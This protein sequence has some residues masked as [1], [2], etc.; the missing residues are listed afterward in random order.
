MKIFMKLTN[1]VI[2]SLTV[3]LTLSAGIW[4][5]QARAGRGVMPAGDTSAWYDCDSKE[6]C[7]K[8]IRKHPKRKACTGLADVA[9]F[10]IQGKTPERA[11]GLADELYNQ[12]KGW[13]QR[14]VKLGST[15]IAW[16]RISTN[17]SFQADGYSTG[18]LTGSPKYFSIEYRSDDGEHVYFDKDTQAF[19]PPSR[20]MRTQSNLV[21]YY[22]RAFK[23][24]LGRIETGTYVQD[25]GKVT[26]HINI[27]E[28]YL[29]TAEHSE[30][31]SSRS[32]CKD[33][34]ESHDQ[35]TDRAVAKQCYGEIDYEGKTYFLGCAVGKTMAED[36]LVNQ[37]CKRGHKLIA[38]ARIY[39]SKKEFKTYNLAFAD[40]SNKFKQALDQHLLW[41]QVRPIWHPIPKSIVPG[42]FDRTSTMEYQI[43][44]FCARTM[45]SSTTFGRTLSF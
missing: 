17:V 41:S 37:G 39:Q 14:Y 28:A 23:G 12:R 9:S 32:K 30:I 16:N 45:D 40:C 5:K 4:T 29:T 13:T 34:F 31:C 25:Y 18:T 36:M 7:L 6:D 11:I 27:E 19:N 1:P 42:F 2:L 33:S 35:E 24:F 8:K 43:D 21:S 20:K 22:H 38:N 26:Q 44:N 15:P 10:I 3:S